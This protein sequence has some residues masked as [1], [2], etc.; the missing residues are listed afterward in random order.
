MHF[1]IFKQPI[2]QL[3]FCQI[4]CARSLFS[5]DT[6]AVDGTREGL[7]NDDEYADSSPAPDMESLMQY[8]ADKN[9]EFADVMQMAESG[10]VRLR[11]GPV[12]SA[13]AVYFIS[14]GA[15]NMVLTRNICS[16]LNLRVLCRVAPSFPTTFGRGTRITCMG[17]SS[18]GRCSACSSRTRSRSP[19]RHRPVTMYAENA[20]IPMCIFWEMLSLLQ[21][22]H[23]LW[24]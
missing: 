15:H 19:R 23:V 2:A 1:S 18:S 14:T 6:C 21:L 24:H 17:C 20:S 16:A 22:L 10:M 9:M 13:R 8:A 7:D 5:S 11:A 4:S 12:L 3:N